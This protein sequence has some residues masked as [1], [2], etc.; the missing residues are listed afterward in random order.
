MENGQHP[1]ASESAHAGEALQ[2]Y[3]VS[4]R[5]HAKRL[6][7]LSYEK[8]LQRI[9]VILTSHSLVDT[10]PIIEL[11]RDR[12]FSNVTD[13]VSNVADKAYLRSYRGHDGFYR[14]SQCS[15]RG[16]NMSDLRR[17]LR[18][19]TGE[20]PFM[21]HLCSR[22]FSRKDHLEKHLIHIHG[23]PLSK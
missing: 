2:V 4:A 19:H 22:G 13:S 8:T 12:M 18:T 21:C 1:E 9:C 20:K 23:T 17:H 15:F 14:C 11:F 3:R 7:A 5:F 16:V 6:S 10:W